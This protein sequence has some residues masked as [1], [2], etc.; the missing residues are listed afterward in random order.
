MKPIK[1][2]VEGTEHGWRFYIN[3]G[4]SWCH[5]YSRQYDSSKKAERAAR[6][7]IKRAEKDGFEVV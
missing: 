3:Y 6:R 5:P 2:S 7:F 1:V 4:P